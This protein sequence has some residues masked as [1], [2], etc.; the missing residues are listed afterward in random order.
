MDVPAIFEFSVTWQPAKP[1]T[2]YLIFNLHARLS[3][4]AL[5]SLLQVFWYLRPSVHF[6]MLNSGCIGPIRALFRLSYLHRG[7]HEKYVAEDS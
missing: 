1:T 4:S 2:G 3:Q 5:I 7:H 6:R